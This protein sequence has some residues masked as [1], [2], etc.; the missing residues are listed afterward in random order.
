MKRIRHA[1]LLVFLT[2]LT[3]WPLI[4]FGLVRANGMNAAALGAWGDHAMPSPQP[5]LI[6]HL[7]DS[8]RR[9]R[10]ALSATPRSV[11]NIA[12]DFLERRGALGQLAEPAQLA[13]AILAAFDEPSSVEISVVTDRLD[14]GSAR[15]GQSRD[16]YSYA[17]GDFG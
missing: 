3:V 7:V 10:I 8:G 16:D 9:E 2:A 14:P 17:R 5:R 15:I 1:L 4:Q 12:R 13:G 6:I 11:Q